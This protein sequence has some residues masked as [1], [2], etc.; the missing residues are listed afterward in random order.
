MSGCQQESGIRE[1]RSVWLKSD[2]K[3]E[4]CDDGTVLD[5]DCGGSYK[6]TT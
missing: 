1:K 6:E 3:R 5:L 4:P 2:S